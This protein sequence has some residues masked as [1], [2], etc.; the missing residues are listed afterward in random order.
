MVEARKPKTTLAAQ[1]DRAR[2]IRATRE[3]RRLEKQR[4]ALRDQACSGARADAAWFEGRPVADPGMVLS[5][6]TTRWGEMGR[7]SRRWTPRDA[8]DLEDMLDVMTE[9]QARGYRGPSSCGPVLTAA[10]LR[11]GYTQDFCE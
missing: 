7:R 1:H 6:A 11:A 3:I 2:L 4:Q 5:A 9:R 10:K 8:C